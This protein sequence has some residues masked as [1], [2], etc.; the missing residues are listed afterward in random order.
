MSA[1]TLET[2]IGPEDLKDLLDA[3]SPVRL[4]D[5]REN[6]EWHTCRIEGAQLIPLSQFTD[7]APAKLGDKDQHLV[8]YC[9]HGMRSMRATLWLRQQGYRQT[10]SLRG[11]IDLWSELIDP[12]V[13]RY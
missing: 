1:S 10:Q 5:C 8:V 12:T 13:P 11:G 3:Q 2:E 9:H 4:V 7:L 6:D